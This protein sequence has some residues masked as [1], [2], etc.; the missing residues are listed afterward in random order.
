PGPIRRAPGTGAGRAS[1]WRWWRPSSRRTAA[2]SSSRRPPGRARRS[3]FACR[4]TRSRRRILLDRE[5]DL[6]AVGELQVVA[7]RVGDE[8]PIADRRTGVVGAE[9]G[10]ALV[11]GPPAAPVH[12]R[13]RLDTDPELREARQ[14]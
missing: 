8:R 7:V 6:L 11:P 5:A 4:W 3:G 14:P 13:P 10:A 12:R 1:A 2:G 9:H